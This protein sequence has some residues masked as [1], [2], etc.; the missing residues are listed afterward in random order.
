M[1]PA[2]LAGQRLAALA[3]SLHRDLERL[4]AHEQVARQLA[5]QWTT[6]RDEPAQRAWAAMTLHAWYTG[7]ESLVERVL[8]QV[9]GEV[10]TGAESHR[11]VLEQAQLELPTVRP[12]LVPADADLPLR[13][14]LAFRHFFRNAYA[15]ELDPQRLEENLARLLTA[16][17][18]VTAQVR[19][20]AEF[21]ERAAETARRSDTP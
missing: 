12:A 8:R 6:R 15:V 10:P 17:P 3:A 1:S 5:A 13:D 2:V 14:L 16:A 19:S 7:L 20:V 9:D 21:F 18:L 4:G 11:R